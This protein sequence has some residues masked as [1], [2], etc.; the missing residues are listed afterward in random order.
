MN[1][2]V[3]L[4]SPVEIDTEIARIY[5]EAAELQALADGNRL[6]I[7]RIDKTLKSSSW[8]SA[9][10][11]KYYSDKIVTLTD[12]AEDAE[13]ESGNRLREALP[14]EQAWRDRGYWNRYYLVTSSDGHV[15]SSTACSTCYPITSYGWLTEYSGMN[16]PKFVTEVA[17]EKACT[18]CY[19][20]AP[21]D[22]L[23]QKTKLELPERR[24]RRI[25]REQK[26]AAKAAKAAAAA[27]YAVDGG[28]LLDEDGSVIKTL[29]SARISVVEHLEDAMLDAEVF[30]P[31]AQETK[32]AEEFAR[33]EIDRRASIKGHALTVSRLIPAIAAKEGRSIEEVTVELTKKANAKMAPTR[34]DEAARKA[35]G[36]GVLEYYRR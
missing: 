10:E 25:E 20:W 18:E 34:K 12:A 15:H 13:I 22:V 8:F 3:A 6:Q 4:S 17:G 14:F 1:I 23:R 19:P 26:A 16:Q 31:Q 27:I 9:E 35:Q 21:V 28:E 33:Y 7:T 11:V 36:K 2:D 29:R 5:G 32:D 30:L 24:A